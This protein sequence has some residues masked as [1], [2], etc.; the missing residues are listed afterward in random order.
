MGGKSGYNSNESVYETSPSM[1]K[2]IFPNGMFINFIYRRG[3]SSVDGTYKLKG[4]IY[5]EEI[6]NS[7]NKSQEGK[8]NPLR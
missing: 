8:N 2:M 7:F 6:V 4:D 1:F 5:T 3:Q